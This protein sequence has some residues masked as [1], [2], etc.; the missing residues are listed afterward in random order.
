MEN[1]ETSFS[2][3]YSAEQQREIEGIRKKYLPKEEDKMAQLRRLHNSATQKAQA[4]AIALGVIGALILGT[5]MSLAMTDL[6]AAF[7]VYSMPVGVLVGLAGL[8]P[9]ALAYPVYNTVL[10]KERQRIAPEILRL[11]EELLH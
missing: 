8:V 11:T 5:G 7:G 9:V 6:G 3:T 10:K 2:Y 4:W 1:K